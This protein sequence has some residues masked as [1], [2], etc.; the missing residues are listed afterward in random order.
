MGLAP[1][2]SVADSSF[3]DAFNNGN[4]FRGPLNQVVISG[5]NKRFTAGFSILVVGTSGGIA[6]PGGAMGVLVVQNNGASVYKFYNSGVKNGDGRWRR[7]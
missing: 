3:R 7:I 5:S 6:L 1:F 4:L 2:N